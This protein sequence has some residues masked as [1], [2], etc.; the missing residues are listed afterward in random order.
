[1]QI[2]WWLR[3]GLH[4]CVRIYCAVI[5]CDTSNIY[6]ERQSPSHKH[7]QTHTL[8][9]TSV[10]TLIICKNVVAPEQSP[11]ASIY[12]AYTHIWSAGLS[13]PCP[14]MGEKLKKETRNVI[15]IFNLIK[16]QELIK[17]RFY[18][19]E[20]PTE[21]DTYESR[22]FFLRSYTSRLKTWLA[23]KLKRHDFDTLAS[24]L[25]SMRLYRRVIGLYGSL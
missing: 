21:N 18:N 4:I 20:L 17:R 9:T 24:W 13:H 7:T 10:I 16:R 14:S 3:G 12:A 6:K 15:C 19:A 1:M 8:Q 5:P 11:Q 2:I 23:K 25:Y 22:C